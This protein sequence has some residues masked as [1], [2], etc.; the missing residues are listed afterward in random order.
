MEQSDCCFEDDNEVMKEIHRT[1]IFA[2]KNCSPKSWS[3]WEIQST[4][5][6]KYPLYLYHPATNPIHIT[7]LYSNL[8]TDRH[9]NHLKL[10]STNGITFLQTHPTEVQNGAKSLHP[11]GFMWACD[12]PLGPWCRSSLG[13][14]QIYYHRRRVPR[15]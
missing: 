10:K 6:Y 15:L 5:Y 3:L 1:D 12:A 11:L 9:T 13:A 8:V 14:Q 7:P 4:N 2:V